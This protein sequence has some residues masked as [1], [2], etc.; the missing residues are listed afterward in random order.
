MANKL[1]NKPSPIIL[2]VAAAY[3]FEVKYIESLDRWTINGKLSGGVTLF[4]SS[5][6]TDEAFFSELR[7]AFNQEGV[8]QQ[9]PY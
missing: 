5:L 9:V 4:W 6:E 1:T 7:S 8:E 2:H 3:G